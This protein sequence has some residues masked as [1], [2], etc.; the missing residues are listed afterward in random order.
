MIGG[1]EKHILASTQNQELTYVHYSAP[2]LVSIKGYICRM[3]VV[4]HAE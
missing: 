4:K 2:L 1:T 3:H